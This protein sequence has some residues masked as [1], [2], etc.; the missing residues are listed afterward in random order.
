MIYY[1]IFKSSQSFLDKNTLIVYNID[2]GS[3]YILLDRNTLCADEGKVEIDNENDCKKA[4][5]NIGFRRKYAGTR[6]KSFVPRG[7]YLDAG[8]ALYNR[9]SVGSRHKKD[10]PICITQG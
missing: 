7:C 4:A 10:S 1:F 8:F 6:N 2:L 3:L 9:H 5:E